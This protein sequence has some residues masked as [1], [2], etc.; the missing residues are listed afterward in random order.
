MASF[1]RLTGDDLAVF[2]AVCLCASLSKGHGATLDTIVEQLNGSVE[3]ASI[4]LYLARLERKEL[5]ESDGKW[6]PAL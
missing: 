5:R 6:K 1:T 4:P 3:R 2:E